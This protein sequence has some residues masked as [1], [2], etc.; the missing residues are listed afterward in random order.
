MF[1]SSGDL[2]SEIITL[3][4]DSSMTNSTD[5]DVKS[6]SILTNNDTINSTTIDV[7]GNLV[8]GINSIINSTNLNLNSDFISNEN[9]NSDV[10]IN[11]TNLELKDNTI[12][13]NIA[14]SGV[15]N[16]N[17]G[18]LI[19]NI[20]ALTDGSITIN[21]GVVKDLALN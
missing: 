5:F 10:N 11:S 12:V 4:D 13:G 9:V 20:N 3:S 8:S 6:G 17:G 14:S 7:N 18:A 19:G 16:L 2:F 15:V 21:D 1:N